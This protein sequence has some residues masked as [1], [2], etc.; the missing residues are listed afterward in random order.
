MAGIDDLSDDDLI[1]SFG[2]GGQGASGPNLDAMSD[3]DLLKT[4]SAK[5]AEQPKMAQPAGLWN[6]AQNFASSV[7]LGAG[8]PLSAATQAAKETVGEISRGVPVGRAISDFGDYYDQAKSIISNAKAG[9]EQAH[10]TAAALTHAGGNIVGTAPL[11]A[12]GGGVAELGAGALTRAAPALE[13]AVDFLSGAAQGNKL[14]RAGSLAANGAIQGVTGNLLTAGDSDQSAADLAKTGAIG[15]AALGVA[16]PAVAAAGRGAWNFLT[17]GGVNPETADLA[18]K[19]IN[20]FNIPIRGGQISGS[21][22]VRYTDSALGQLPFTG[23][24]GKTE[25]AHDAFTKAVS[26]TFG[27]DTPAITQDVMQR[28]K[29]RIGSMFDT[30][31]ANTN[32]RVDNQLGSDL[33]GVIHDASQALPQSEL[34][35]IVKQVENIQ[36]LAQN[37]TIPGDAYAALT[38]KGAPLD[39]AMSSADPNIRY[40]AGQLRSSLDDALQRSAPPE[41]L[42]TLHTARLQYKNMKTIEDLAE[43]S[44]DGRI[45]PA[46]LLNQVRKSYNN[47]AYQGAG[48][49]GELAQIGQRFLKEPPNSGTSIRNFIHGA[50]GGAGTV[51]ELALGMH[52]PMYAL[53]GLGSAAGGAA[54]SKGLA[55]ALDNPIYRNALIRSGQGQ[56]GPVAQAMQNRLSNLSSAAIPAG[57][58]LGN[59][60]LM[61]S[62]VNP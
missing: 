58:I 48:D 16:L 25:A 9:Y 30:V 41:M 24:A 40:Y 28:A 22:F 39:R 17:G 47:Y 53:Y 31:A 6:G 3:D 50:I 62:A 34:A 35:P 43:K 29:D 32:I 49:I 42:D 44:S 18:D 7:L 46:L 4:F 36:G 59:R 15:G 52:D 12:M 56:V 1:A 8:V 27:E 26:N 38:R 13:P 57:V 20:K 19:A 10:P 60:L 45:T 5:P 61:P 23:Y 55:L 54:V 51:G 2:K 21:P 11:M 37:G 33:Q 14:I